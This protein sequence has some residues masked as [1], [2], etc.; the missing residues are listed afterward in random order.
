MDRILSKLDE[1]TALQNK[2]I[3]LE[4]TVDTLSSTVATLNQEV[5][6]LKE[7]ENNRD[8]KERGNSAR[9]FGISIGLD[10]EDPA[11]LSKR[12]YDS[13][14]R[15]VLV[16]AKANKHIEAVP[17]LGNAL[18]EVYRARGSSKP[19]IVGQP[20]PPPPPIIV[21]FA[22]SSIK[23]AFFMNKKASMPAPSALEM[24]AGIKRYTAVED[25]TV[26]C[27]KKLREMNDCVDIDKVWS[28]E[29][30][31]RFTLPG[32]NTVRKVKSVFDSLQ[33]ITNRG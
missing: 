24:A 33:V 29:G 30:K 27:Y 12:V 23:K 21:K 11:A 4:A 16:A 28:V 6:L 17:H 7:K 26:V 22:S 15:P 32:D 9:F 18:K 14:V 13:V 25:L 19:L 1:L 31:L 8:Q 3:Q 10:E 5:A 2:V 20:P